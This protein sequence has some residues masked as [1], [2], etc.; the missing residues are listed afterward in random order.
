MFWDI[1]VA[2]FCQ[3][4][5][6]QQVPISSVYCNSRVC[7]SILHSSLLTGPF[8]RSFVFWFTFKTDRRRALLLR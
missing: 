4:V 7:L 5:L 2:N 3:E 6:N 8:L 1:K